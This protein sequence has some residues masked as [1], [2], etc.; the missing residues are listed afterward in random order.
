M[1]NGDIFKFEE[2]KVYQHS[3][4]FID[5]VREVTRGFQTREDY[6]LRDQFHR[7]ALSICLNI[8]EGS[9]GTKAEC[10]RY[11]SIAARSVR[12]CVA[13]AEVLSRQKKINAGDRLAI[14]DQC[15]GIVRM[16][17]GLSRSLKTKGSS[18][19]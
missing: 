19:E 4:D 2:L 1:T 14:R 13:I 7:A 15:T 18:Q 5:K 12:E 9:G 11:L 6:Y 8:A 3:L 16:I 17:Y 10:A